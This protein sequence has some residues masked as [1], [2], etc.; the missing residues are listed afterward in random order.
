MTDW[1]AQESRTR[2]EGPLGTASRARRWLL[3]EQPGSWGRDAL[4]ASDLPAAVAEQLEAWSREVPVRVLL[5]RRPGGDRPLGAER[6]LYAG[7]SAPQGSWLEAIELGHVREVLDLD[8]SPLRDGRSIGGIRVVD[9]LYL[10]CTNGKHDPCCAKFGL[11]VA[12]SLL[13]VV[14]DRVWECSHVGGDRFAGNLVCLPDG[15]FYGHLD[16][17]TARVAVAANEGGR[18]D[19]DHFRGRSCH[20][21]PVQAAEALARQRMGL[22]G[23]G[24]L[25]VVDVQRAG[26][27]HRVRFARPGGRRLVVEVVTRRDAPPAPLT[28]GGLPGAA[29]SYELVH[30]AED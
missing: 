8:V 9:P 11:P 20:A 4:R 26:D 19:L 23:T 18:I 2:G 15:L 25:R 16:A 27:R 6:L 13:D 17:D 7:V 3:L 21:F 5:L 12:Q 29:P 10:V 1:C 28:C 24:A 30:L 22:Q 14:G